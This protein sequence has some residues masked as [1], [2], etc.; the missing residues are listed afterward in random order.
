MRAPIG[1][2]SPTGPGAQPW[3][4]GRELDERERVAAGGGMQPARGVGRDRP[5]GMRGEQRACRLGG[6]ACKHQLLEPGAVDRRRLARAHGQQHGDRIG[7]QAPRGERQRRRRGPV[8]PLHVVGEDDDR[9]L[10]RERR[11]QAERRRADE[12]GLGR[13]GRREPERGLER[14][15]LRAGQAPELAEHRAQQLVQPAEC[16]LDLRL[17]AAHAQHGGGARHRGGVLEQRRLADPRLA[18]Q[19][20]HPARA[21]AAPRHQ[22][23]DA[24]ALRRAPQQHGAI[25]TARVHVVTTAR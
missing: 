22:R 5:R 7:E 19:H 25:L 9:P 6:E 15:A 20:E 4:L 24:P 2:W 3:R 11:Q 14:D 16:D 18:A 8:D 1:T 21:L 10:L 12:M 13:G 23:L 17:D